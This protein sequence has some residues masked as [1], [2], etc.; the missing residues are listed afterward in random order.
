MRLQRVDPL[1][2]Q[3][4]DARVLRQLAIE[5]GAVVG[6]DLRPEIEIRRAELDRVGVGRLAD[7][8]VI[9][10]NQDVFHEGATFEAGNKKQ[11]IV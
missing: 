1:Q 7:D 8:V 11:S 4:D 2:A 9:A 6:V 10:F 3:H 5:G